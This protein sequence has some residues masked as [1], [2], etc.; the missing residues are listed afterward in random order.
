MEILE[1]NFDT[2]CTSIIKY[3]ISIR[4]RELRYVKKNIQVVV[5]TFEILFFSFWKF[6]CY[7]HKK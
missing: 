6:A 3:I 7:A 5:K 4:D 1:I 2:L